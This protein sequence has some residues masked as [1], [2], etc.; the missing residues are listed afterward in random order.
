MDSEDKKMAIIG[1]FAFVAFFGFIAALVI[2]TPSDRD[3]RMELHREYMK[4]I[5]KFAPSAETNV[6]TQEVSHGE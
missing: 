4:L 3:E 2:F 1:S 5:A 6:V